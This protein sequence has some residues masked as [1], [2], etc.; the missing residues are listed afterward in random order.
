MKATRTQWEGG[1]LALVWAPADAPTG[2][3]VAL[4]GTLKSLGA[5]RVDVQPIFAPIHT[6]HGDE[7]YVRVVPEA[8]LRALPAFDIVYCPGPL[9]PHHFWDADLDEE[10]AEPESEEPDEIEE[11]QIDDD[12][13]PRLPDD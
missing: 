10:S 2:A 4:I 13:A 8:K 7:T 3:V 11:V 5:R 12:F 9:H 1:P 6:C